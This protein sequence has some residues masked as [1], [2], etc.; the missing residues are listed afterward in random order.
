MASTSSS[1]SPTITLLDCPVDIL[2]AVFQ[3][4]SPR[5]LYAVCLVC[6]ASSELAE[7]L[8]YSQIH[9]T[10]LSSQ[11]PQ[12]T[13][14]LRSILLKPQLA[15]HIQSLVLDGDTFHSTE[16]AGRPPKISVGGT[17]LDESIAFV[18]KVNVP[19]GGLWIQEPRTGKMDAF[20]AVL[21]SQLSSLKCLRM[22]PNFAKN[23]QI[24][25]IMLRSALS[26]EN[27]ERLSIS[28]DLS[29]RQTTPQP[30]ILLTALKTSWQS[31]LTICL[32]KRT[33]PS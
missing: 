17:E 6:K 29:T 1:S 16:N 22:S 23:S 20:V 4:C 18:K 27:G 14:L 7:P 12:I 13:L 2:Q 33:C 25:G 8:L 10:W 24:V 21:L 3:S 31:L 30:E 11:T 26:L 9:W 5:D 19:Y 15:V 28:M 32:T